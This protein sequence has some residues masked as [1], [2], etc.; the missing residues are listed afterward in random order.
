MTHKCRK[1]AWIVNAHGAALA[2]VFAVVGR[3]VLQAHDAQASTHLGNDA[4]RLDNCPAQGGVATVA[5]AV[6][7]ANSKEAKICAVFATK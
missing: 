2:L 5:L 1:L 7:D 3:G 6:Q 4:C